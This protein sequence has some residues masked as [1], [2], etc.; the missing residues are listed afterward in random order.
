MCKRETSGKVLLPGGCLKTWP[1]REA[2]RRRLLVFLLFCLLL[3]CHEGSSVNDFPLQRVSQI[4]EPNRKRHPTSSTGCV[5]NTRYCGSM[6]AVSTQLCIERKNSLQ[7]VVG[8]SSLVAGHTIPRTVRELAQG[9][10]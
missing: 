5:L 1:L 9:L 4:T 8:R 3:R 6:N 2:S 10:G 7:T